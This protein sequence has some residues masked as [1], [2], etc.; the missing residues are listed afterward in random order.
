MTK[1]GL[2]FSDGDSSLGGSISIGDVD[3]LGV[4]EVVVGLGVADGLEPEPESSGAEFVVHCAVNVTP[5]A[6][7]V[8]VWPLW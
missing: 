6:G 2:S 8:N 7:I 3:S 5:V 4:G 1:I